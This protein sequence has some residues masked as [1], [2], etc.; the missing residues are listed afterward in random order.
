[1]K[2][3][4]QNTIENTPIC[5][6]CHVTA[7]YLG[8]NNLINSTVYTCYAC[9]GMLEYDANNKIIYNTLGRPILEGENCGLIK[10]KKYKL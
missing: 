10:D 2:T 8:K 9:G 4:K 1:M 7:I 5:P 3:L 6:S